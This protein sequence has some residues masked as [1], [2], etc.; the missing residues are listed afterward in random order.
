MDFEMGFIE[1]EREPMAALEAVIR[2]VVS[3]VSKE[4]ADMFARFNTTPPLLP[5]EIPI[6]TLKEALAQLGK[7]EAPDMEPE[8]ER[9]I[10]EWATKEK[11]SDF[12]FFTLFPSSKRA[13][14]T[15]EDPSEAPFSRGFDLLFR[16]L[17]INS[18]AQRIHNYDS[19]IERIK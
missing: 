7:P 2:D 3:S 10:C 1:N 17:E 13:F 4:H 16:G 15:Y 11:V 6:L 9:G 8:D 12:V 5:K 19:L 18:G 14:Y